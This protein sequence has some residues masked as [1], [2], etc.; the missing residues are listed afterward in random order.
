[1][2][3][4]KRISR[5]NFLIKLR[6]WEYWP[7]GILQFPLIVYWFWLSLRARSLLF[8][9]ASNPGIEMGGMFGESKFEVIKKIPPELIP[10]TIL[11]KIPVTADKVLQSLEAEEFKLPVIFKPEFGER[12]YMVRRIHDIQDIG[13]YL[14]E[15]KT[16]FLVQELVDLPLEFGVFYTRFPNESEGRVT[17]V[18][19]KEML[20]VT[21]N[22]I[23]T[24]QQLILEND[25][26]KLQWKKLKQTFSKKLHEIIPEGNA[27]ELVSIGNHSLGTKFLD[28]SHLINEDLS[29]TFDHI[30]K[31]I[32]GFYFGRYD[33]R[34]ISLQH[35][36]AGRVKI[37]ELNGCGAEPAHIYQPGFSFFKAVRILFIHW[38]NIFV[39]AKQNH[40]KG[41]P[42]ITWGEARPL[43][44]RFKDATK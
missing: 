20:T 38:R 33:L 13:V 4:W 24:L 10:K 43:Y 35:L 1:M 31:Q 7:F 21:G 8:F 14:S 2:S 6:S 9:S 15:I 39:I 42:Y 44:K 19:M 32:A 25:R 34:C 23:S 11:V 12:G 22:G 28:G 3:L 30:S 16:N 18:V 29:L 40:Q 5:S 37:M 36:Y 17:S 27:I 26:A 41:V